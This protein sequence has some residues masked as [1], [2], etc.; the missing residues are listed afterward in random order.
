MWGFEIPNTFEKYEF[1]KHEY[2]F[3]ENLY[4]HTHTETH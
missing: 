4:T 3:K 1:A 2:K